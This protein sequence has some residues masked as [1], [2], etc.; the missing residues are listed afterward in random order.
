MQILLSAQQRYADA[1]HHCW[2]YLIGDAQQPLTVAYNDD[3]EPSGTAG[4]PILHVLTQRGAGDTLAVVSRYFGGIKLGAG[5][6]VRAYGQTVSKALDAAQLSVNV[7]LCLVSIEVD[8]A[9]ED[10][11]RHTL[12]Q[13]AAL[14][15]EAQ[16]QARV[17]LSCQLPE[18]SKQQ[19]LQ[20]LQERCGGALRIV[21]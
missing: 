16:Y 13:H 20:L 5:G 1:R 7:P 8:Y 6:L 11:C 18:H 3:G 10:L 14:N 19:T 2:A 12:V 17:T 4:K 9:L 21:S 15:V